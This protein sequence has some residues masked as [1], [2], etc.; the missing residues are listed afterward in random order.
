MLDIY[1]SRGRTDLSKVE[2]GFKFDEKAR[3]IAR[4]FVDKWV[5]FGQSQRC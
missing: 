3:T 2:G 4:V 1:I 5:C